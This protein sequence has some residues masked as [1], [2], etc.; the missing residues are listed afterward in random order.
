VPLARVESLG[1]VDFLSTRRVVVMVVPHELVEMLERLLHDRYLI[2]LDI[3][4]AKYQ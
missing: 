1:Q 2:C 3:S 4:L